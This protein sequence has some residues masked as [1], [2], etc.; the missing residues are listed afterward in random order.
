MKNK[1]IEISI[2]TAKKKIDSDVLF[3][4]VREKEELQEMAYAISNIVNIPLSQFEKRFSELPKDRELVMVCRRGRRSLIATE[5]LLS[6]GFSKVSNMH[7]GILG[8][9]DAGFPV[10]SEKYN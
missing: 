3:V 10:R 7:G 9:I 5:F 6:Q 4:D 2:E 1:P 8:W